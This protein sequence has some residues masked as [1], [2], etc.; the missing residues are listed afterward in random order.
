MSSP[1]L[2]SDRIT[3]TRAPAFN[4]PAASCA[5]AAPSTS[6]SSW[7]QMESPRPFSDDAGRLYK[8]SF[9]LDPRIVNKT[10]DE[11]VQCRR[12]EDRRQHVHGRGA[13]PIS[14]ISS[15][16]FTRSNQGR[17]YYSDLNRLGE[18]IFV[19]YLR[20][21]RKRFSSQR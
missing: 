2:L 4:L 18:F 6:R 5:G 19:D 3:Q 8:N 16:S 9:G 11:A 7:S 13:T 20:N 17:A 15:K 14:S 1:F 10:L 21:R 12:G